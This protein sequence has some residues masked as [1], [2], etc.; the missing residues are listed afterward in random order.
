MS[1]F[2]TRIRDVGRA[3][4]GFG[5]AAIAR[6]ERPRYMLVVA[7]AAT[8]AE[9]AQAEAIGVDAILYTGPLA[10]LPQVV[11]ASR[12]SVGAHIAAATHD[13]ATRAK[14]AGAD[15]IT[16]DDGRTHASALT[17]RELGHVLILGADQ[18]EQRLRSVAAVELDAVLVEAESDVITVREQIELRRVAILT[19]APLLVRAMGTPNAGHLEGWRDAGAPVVLVP[20]AI[21]ETTLRAAAE[22]P[23]P[24]KPTSGEGGAVIGAPFAPRHDHDHGDED[25]D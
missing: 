1:K 3:I 4:G 18:D 22:V 9:A 13:D 17:V 19:G 24:R 16:F 23:A 15:F 25:D 2:R 11:K 12:I 7:E 6:K 14:E 21:A 20:A 8:P 10:D 5:F